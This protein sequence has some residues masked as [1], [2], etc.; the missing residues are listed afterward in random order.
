MPN[1]CY[2]N[3][4]FKGTKDDIR[5]FIKN[6]ILDI[7]DITPSI[8][9]STTSHAEWDDYECPIPT[10]M[11]P[12]IE[13]YGDIISIEHHQ[14]ARRNFYIRGTYRC[15]IDSNFLEIN[16]ELAETP[17]EE[18]IVCI[19]GFKAAWSFN[20][21]NDTRWADIASDYNMDIKMVGFEKGMNF[22]QIKTIYRDRSVELLTKEYKDCEDWDWNSLFPNYGG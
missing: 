5:N 13:E 7:I 14:N 6:E 8:S 3:I 12:I 16:L 22:Y 19:D 1:W 11:T 10:Q 9:N 4:R 20:D 18:I 2:G 17:L 21:I 15:F